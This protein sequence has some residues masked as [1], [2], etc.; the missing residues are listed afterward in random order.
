M[1]DFSF[2]KNNPNDC[3][4]EKHR[5]NIPTLRRV[6]F[7]QSV[8]TSDERIMQFCL[9]EKQL[10][11]EQRC[12]SRKYKERRVHSKIKY[13][14]KL[15]VQKRKH[16]S[17]HFERQEHMIL[18]EHMSLEKKLEI[19]SDAA[20]YD[21][22]CTS[23]GVTRRGEKGCLGNTAA[24]G[25]CHSFAADGR[26][27]SLLK[28]LFSN[29]CVY[30]C[31]YCLNRASNDVPRATFTPEE[32]CTLTVEFYRR[33][34]IEGLFLSSGII[35]TPSHTMGLLYQTLLLLRRQYRFNG[36]IHVKTIPGADPELIQKI[37]YLADRMS[38]N[39]E[40]STQ[41]GL[42]K[43]A[44]HKTHARILAP[45][46]QI[47]NSILQ[48]RLE[49]RAEGFLPP[50]RTQTGLTVASRNQS[51]LSPQI[52]AHSA[53][54][55]H[56]QYLAR[57][58]QTVS[59][60]HPR[61]VPAGQSTQMIVGAV[62]ESDFQLVRTAEALYQNYDLKR[63]F[64]SAYVPVNEDAS[65]PSLDT[66]PPL[67]REHRLYQ[68]DW[69]L[70][71]YG[72]HA[73]ELLTEERPNFNL[74]I[75]PKCDWAV[76]HLEL[77]PVEITSADYATLLRVPGIGVKSAR[78]IL[79]ARKHSLLDFQALKKMGVVLKRAHYFITVNGHMLY[80]VKL[81]E[82]YITHNL[83]RSEQDKN[84]QIAREMTYQQMSLFDDFQLV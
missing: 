1:F 6:R 50:P 75:D 51:S 54:D 74:F 22:A 42:K 60:S 47:Q 79:Y 17:S 53:A 9:M 61:F 32:L 12:L 56:L 68:A 34:Y 44:P 33:N 48:D 58:A 82:T 43:L 3:H 23:S 37:G 73:G 49:G 2:V 40:I 57:T 62:P 18:Q 70:R 36:Y 64:Y 83:I 39:L 7:R 31:K 11:R 65:L 4:W 27:I 38:A 81:E 71:F 25:I 66:R 24:G 84:W 63:V 67:L 46:R 59:R 29:E 20:K 41:E 55:P 69:L 13:T 21:V 30:D 15:T 19:L 77:F 35:N 8:L 78:R 5:M 76:R 52:P 14:K 10:I 16:T 26:C 28:V 72:F 80:P 45:I